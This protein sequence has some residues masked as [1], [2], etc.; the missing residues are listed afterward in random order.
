MSEAPW[1]AELGIRKRARPVD[2]NTLEYVYSKR[3]L[4]TPDLHFIVPKLEKKKNSNDKKVLQ[5]PKNPGKYT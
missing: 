2:L 3:N 4:S 5:G 1:K